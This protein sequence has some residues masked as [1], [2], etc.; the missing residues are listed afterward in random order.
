MEKHM[1]MLKCNQI[2]NITL[3]TI[4]VYTSLWL[5]QPLLF[6]D[7]S[8]AAAYAQ[9][10]STQ[11]EPANKVKVVDGLVMPRQPLGKALKDAM[12]FLKKSDGGYIPGEPGAKH[13]GYFLSCMVHADGKPTKPRLAFP[14]RHH[15]YF[16]NTFLRYYAYSGET[17]WLLR[18]RDLADWNIANSTD[19]DWACPNLPYSTYKNGKPRGGQDKN[20]IEPDKAA[21]IG[22]AYLALFDSTG[23]A[24]YLQAARK[25]A[26]TL[27]K[28]Q[29]ENGG[30]DFRIIPEDA[31]VMQDFGGA[32]VNFV[33]LFE[34]LL[35]KEDNP[36]YQNARDK[37]L[38]WML[39]TN[40]QDNHWGVYHEDVDKADKTYMTT[41]LMCFTAAYL[42][43]HSS[44]HQDYLDMGLQVLGHVQKHFVHLKDHPVAPAPAVSE[45]PYCNHI[46]PGHTARYCSVLADLYA[47]TG[48]EQYKRS[49]ISSIN[50]T[51]YMQSPYGIFSTWIWNVNKKKKSGLGRDWYS[52]HLYTVCHMMEVMAKLPQLAPDDQDHLLDSKV[53][54]RTI[55][56]AKGSVMFETALP[57]TAVLKLSFVPKRVKLNGKDLAAVQDLGQA[58]EGWSFNTKTRVLK[59]RHGKGKIKIQ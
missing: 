17:E 12:Q 49:A 38:K 7:T 15:A 20:S 22:S 24:K 10:S 11:Q 47:F 40:V 58:A 16:I 1:K 36:A 59:I 55:A 9:E 2:N 4:A 52:Q 54:V 42:I 53:P 27:L 57:S 45:Q 30:W 44:E 51:T 28:I 31:S 39:K 34:Q 41:E 6:Q 56:Y 23:Q 14:A 43:R 37:A 35:A 48:N 46:M 3:I 8:P 26:D 32:I 33:T 29:R 5:A 13:A 18:A 25:I 21:F 50:G 19:T